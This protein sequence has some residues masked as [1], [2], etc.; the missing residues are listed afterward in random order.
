MS[1]RPEV[2]ASWL[3]HAV[4][5]SVGAGAGIAEP[6]EAE[7]TFHTRMRSFADEDRAFATPDVV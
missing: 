5:E 7:E 4:C 6:N 2:P 1:E 3:G